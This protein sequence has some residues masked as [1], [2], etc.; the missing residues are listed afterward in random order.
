MKTNITNLW[1]KFV[2]MDYKLALM[3]ST[4]AWSQMTHPPPSQ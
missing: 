1:V 2:A 4:G 3:M